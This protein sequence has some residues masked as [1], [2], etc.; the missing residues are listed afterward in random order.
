[1]LAA[2]WLLLVQN[3]KHFSLIAQTTQGAAEW[4]LEVDG[5]IKNHEAGWLR[6]QE[7]A[8][9]EARQAE[10]LAQKSR[11]TILGRWVDALHTL[12]WVLCTVQSAS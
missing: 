3:S 7:R 9:E 12:C 8:R 11:E 6:H 2:L 5:D 10:I 4:V 1:M